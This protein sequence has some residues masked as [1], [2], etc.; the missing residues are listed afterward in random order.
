MD[1]IKKK[2]EELKASKDLKSDIDKRTVEILELLHGQL[3]TLETRLW[4][5]ALS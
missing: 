5:G 4:N 2:I 3:M 1:E